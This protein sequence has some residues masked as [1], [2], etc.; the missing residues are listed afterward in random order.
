VGLSFPT[1]LRGANT[2]HRLPWASLA[3]SLPAC[4]AALQAARG[5]TFEPA[6]KDGAPI[7][8][9]VELGATLRTALGELV[10]S[11][12]AFA[13]VVDEHGRPVAIVTTALLHA[14]RERPLAAQQQ[15]QQQHPVEAMQWQQG[16][17][18]HPHRAPG[19]ASA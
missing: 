14:W 9:V 19:I 7:R 15:P 2:Q 16:Q 11:G 4:H 13:P 12:E 17:Y 5:F 1:T 3:Q 8:A 6:R 10:A 18:Q